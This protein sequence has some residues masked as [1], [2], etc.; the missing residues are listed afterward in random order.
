MHH[1]TEDKVYIHF[2]RNLGQI[3]HHESETVEKSVRV[4]CN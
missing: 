3:V 4:G 1:E 2:G